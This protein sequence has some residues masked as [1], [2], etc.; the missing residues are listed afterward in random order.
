MVFVSAAMCIFANGKAD[1]DSDQIVLNYFGKPDTAF[2]EQ[3][4]ADFEADNPNIKINYVELAGG[5]NE[6]LATIQTVLQSQDSTIDVFAADATWPAVFISA[7]WVTP[8]NELLADDFANGLEKE[9]IES[10]LSVF[11]QDGLTYGLPYI[12]NGGIFFYRKDLLEKH[13]KPV[14]TTWAEV[15]ETAKYILAQENNKDLV[16]FGSA[17]KQSEGLTCDVM[18]R[19]WDAGVYIYKDGK[20]DLDQAKIEQALKIMYET[21][22]VDEIALGASTTFGC[23]DVREFMQNGRMLFSRDWLSQTGKCFNPELNTVAEHM[24][25]SAVPGGNT[26]GVWGLMVSNFS[27]HKKEAAMFLK[28]RASKMIQVKQAKAINQLPTV[29][30]AFDDPT[31][32]E[33]FPMASDLLHVMQH[34]KPRPLTPYYGEVSSILQTEV[35]AMLSGMLDYRTAACNIVKRVGE[36]LN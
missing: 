20:V 19:F 6:K 8:I 1:G 16:G 9:Y 15:N 3:V 22:Y 35:H 4:V 10:V 27:E 34:G 17:W 21:I 28:Y 7:G 26:L 18:E 14:P 32:L 12:S 33:V 25:I 5:S 2:E 30:D 23:G 13:N 36:V 11:Q 24:G 31:V 29:I